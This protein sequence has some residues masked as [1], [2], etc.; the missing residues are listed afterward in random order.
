M[1]LEKVKTERRKEAEAAASAL[2]AH[3]IQF[4]DFGDYPL[5]IDTDGKYQIVDLIRA[6]QPVLHDEPLQVGPIQYGSHVCH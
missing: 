2:N 1:T 4:F 3:D 5:E 6:V